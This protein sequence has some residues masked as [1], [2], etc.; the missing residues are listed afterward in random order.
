[1]ILVVGASGNL[2]YEI[3]QQFANLE[4]IECFPRELI[5]NFSREK[6]RFSD[7]G[8]LASLK[9]LRL[10]IIAAGIID[11]NYPYFDHVK[12]NYYLPRNFLTAGKRLGFKTL[13]FGSIHEYSDIKSNYLRSKKL[14]RDFLSNNQNLDFLHFQ[15]NTLYSTYR[16]HPNSFLGQL[17]NCLKNQIEFKMSSG[18]QL[19]QF[20]NTRNIVEKVVE[21]TIQEHSKSM[22]LPICSNQ[23]LSLG[24][25]AHYFFAQAN[26]L[27]L[28][29]THSLPDPENEIYSHEFFTQFAVNL[30]SVDHPLLS[31]YSSL[32]Q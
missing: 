24:Q 11:N 3:T 26:Q 19:R 25:I 27:D 29:Q 4:M 2:G 31:I 7:E 20:H 13:T 16:I 23:V 30:D 1:M 10:V 22:F 9:G 32:M 14:L 21:I 5:S 15:L 18:M 17:R 28:L 12:L 6:L 8:Y